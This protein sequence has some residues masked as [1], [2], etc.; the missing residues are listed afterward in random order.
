MSEMSSF[1]THLL[2]GIKKLAFFFSSH[3]ENHYSV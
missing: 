2:A 3:L 1:F